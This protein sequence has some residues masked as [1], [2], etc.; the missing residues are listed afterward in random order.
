MTAAERARRF[1]ALAV[2]G[3]LLVLLG[4]SVDSTLPDGGTSVTNRTN[5]EI[6]L[7]G[8]CVPDDP[9]TLEPGDTDNDV[10][11][12]AECRVDNGDGEDGVLGCLTLRHTHTDLT[13][14]ALRQIR[15]PDDCWGGG[16]R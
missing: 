4:C 12:G 7:T 1:G 8:N 3:C 10:Y 13:L 11:A 14:D 2:L 5:I 16:V 9:Q 15:G 6:R